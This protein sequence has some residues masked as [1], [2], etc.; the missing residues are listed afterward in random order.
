[1]NYVSHDFEPSLGDTVV[2]NNKRCKHYGSI[3]KV[4]NLKSL[5]KDSGKLVCYRCQNSGANWEVGDTLEKT[6]DQLRPASSSDIN[7][8]EIFKQNESL[9]REYVREK[10]KEE[11]SIKNVVLDIAGL[12][13]FAGEFADIAN[14]IDYA[15]KGNYLFAAFSLISVIPELGDAIGKGGKLYTLTAK[16]GIKN[17]G[18]GGKAISA[19]AKSEKFKKA[20]KYVTK[21]KDLIVKNKSLIDKIFDK[22]EKSENKDIKNAVPKMREAI[23]IFYK[24]ISPDE[25]K[26]SIERIV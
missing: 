7:Q 3:G 8:A 12:I 23:N 13:P 14:A 1:M 16:L 20:S 9:L 15:K 11:T 19:L 22:A 25:N 2:N 24:E 21:L 10:I 5:P 4:T 18:K 6:L 17:L 26:P